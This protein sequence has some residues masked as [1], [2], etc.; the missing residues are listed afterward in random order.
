MSFIKSLSS[1]DFLILFS[2][3]L[4]SFISL[5]LASL[6]FSLIVSG[7]SFSFFSSFCSSPNLTPANVLPKSTMDLISIIGKWNIFDNI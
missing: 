4:F 3:S 5:L 6:L 1:L 2:F 7:F